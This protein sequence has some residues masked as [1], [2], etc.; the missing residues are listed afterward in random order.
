LLAVW[1]SQLLP[2]SRWLPLCLTPLANPPAAGSHRPGPHTTPLEPTCTVVCCHQTIREKHYLTSS[3]SSDSSVATRASMVVAVLP[4]PQQHARG[5]SAPACPP[6]PSST[7]PCPPAPH[8][9]V[10][11]VALASCVTFASLRCLH[12]PAGAS[13]GWPG[14]QGTLCPVCHRRHS[15]RRGSPPSA[16]HDG[17]RPPLGA[18]QSTGCASP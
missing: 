17:A 10:R 3:S 6:G 13:L 16:H 1:I 5:P 7:A 4:L 8:M 11:P 18:R 14:L 15:G 12:A 2:S 9:L